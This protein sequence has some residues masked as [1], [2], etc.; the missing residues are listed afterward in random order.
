MHQDCRL[1]LL[2]VHLFKRKN[3][4]N[5]VW[6][7]TQNLFQENLYWEEKSLLR[8][9]GRLLTPQIR[10]ATCLSSTFKLF[11]FPA[12]SWHSSFLKYWYLQTKVYWDLLFVW[13]SI[14]RVII[15]WLHFLILVPSVWLDGEMWLLKSDLKLI[16]SSLFKDLSLRFSDLLIN[17]K[18]WSSSALYDLWTKR[19]YGWLFS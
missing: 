1:S 16:I 14:D 5:F 9:H 17:Q 19:Y 7:N 4:C 13:R 10:K 11:P 15:H 12:W 3:A 6:V 18:A 2:Q 8:L